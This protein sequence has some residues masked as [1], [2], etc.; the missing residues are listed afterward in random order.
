MKQEGLRYFTDINLTSAGLVIFFGFFVC[1]LFW[2]YRK[3][4][5]D[6]YSKAANLPLMDGEFHG[7]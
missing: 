6:L 5:K 2:V 7:R 3:S 1:L 4:S